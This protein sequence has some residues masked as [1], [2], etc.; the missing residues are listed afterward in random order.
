MWRIVISTTSLWLA[1]WLAKMSVAG[2]LE[3]IQMPL[4]VHAE[5]AAL[6]STLALAYKVHSMIGPSRLA[7][8][9]VRLMGFWGWTLMIGAASTLPAFAGL[10]TFVGLLAE[11]MYMPGGTNS[12]SQVLANNRQAPAVRFKKPFL[13]LD[14]VRS[15]SRQQRPHSRDTQWAITSVPTVQL[16]NCFQG[17]TSV[18]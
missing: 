2:W 4:C 15:P 8:R 11:S 16:V 6:T 13:Q 10:L 9:L 12:N 5:H 14:A 17:A 3:C 7:C 18:W 1:S